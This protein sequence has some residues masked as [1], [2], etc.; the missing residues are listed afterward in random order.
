[1]PT[2]HPGPE[3]PSHALGHA[4]EADHAR[5]DEIWDQGMRLWGTD[6]ARATALFREFTS[7]LL[8][9]IQVEEGMV[10]PFYEEHT[11]RREHHLLELLRE[12]HVQIRDALERFMGHVEAG[13]KE[14]EE[15]STV[16]RNVL[17]AHNTR[18]EGQLY[19]WFGPEVSE[20]EAAELHRTIS[21]MLSS[22]DG[23]G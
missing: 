19:P 18:E 1:M 23:P 6:P 7:G 8:R 10:F 14:L 22:S 9:H 16:L 13:D 17:W 4:L 11:G 15:P 5:L 20:G 21:T 2:D 12:E 3:V